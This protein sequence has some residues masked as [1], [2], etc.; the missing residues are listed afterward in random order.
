MLLGVL[1]A[2]LYVPSFTMRYATH[3]DESLSLSSPAT[4]TSYYVTFAVRCGAPT[5][6]LE[7]L[8]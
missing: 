8:C 7:Y 3:R 5:T 4:C 1:M 2:F 6:V